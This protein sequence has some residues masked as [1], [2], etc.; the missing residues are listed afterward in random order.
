MK[1]KLRNRLGRLTIREVTIRPITPKFDIN[2]KLNGK[3]MATV[4]IDNHMLYVVNP[5]PIIKL[6]A[7][8]LPKEE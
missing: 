7:L 5:C 2:R 6:P 3:P 4:R 8:R 1:R